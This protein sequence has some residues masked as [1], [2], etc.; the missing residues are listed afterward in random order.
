VQGWP[1]RSQRIRV[2]G[3]ANAGSQ[4]AAALA[5]GQEKNAWQYACN[6][7]FHKLGN[8]R[9]GNWM[10]FSMVGSTF[11]YMQIESL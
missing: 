11:D 2:K 5:G 7:E 3:I 8:R 4:D 9:E 1:G 10:A 6:T